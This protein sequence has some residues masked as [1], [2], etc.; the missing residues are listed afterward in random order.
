MP[1]APPTKWPEAHATTQQSLIHQFHTSRSHLLDVLSN[2]AGSNLDIS[3]SVLA[4]ARVGALVGALVGG[5]FS[6][7]RSPRQSISY[8]PTHNNAVTHGASLS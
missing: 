6:S 5:C 7:S 2:V 4:G 3:I 8:V 1:K